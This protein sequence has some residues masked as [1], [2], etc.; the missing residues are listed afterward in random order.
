M[1][2][3]ILGKQFDLLSINELDISDNSLFFIDLDLITID[4]RT[5]AQVI[6]K[7][8]K[9]PL[10]VALTSTRPNDTYNIF[11]IFDSMV[12]KPI[13]TKSIDI[14]FRKIS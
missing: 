2:K 14:M 3:S 10:L 1:V 9:N 6:R 5:I 7:L 4:G 8:N 13:S 12:F 11:R